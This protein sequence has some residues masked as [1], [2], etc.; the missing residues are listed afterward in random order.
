MG[1]LGFTL[2]VALFCINWA[3][4]VG[5]AGQYGNGFTIIYELI[6]GKA[7]ASG[8]R[9]LLNSVMSF[10]VAAGTIL[11][12]AAA[13]VVGGREYAIPIFIISALAEIFLMP[14]DVLNNVAMPFEIK[15]LLFGL[16][17]IMLISAVVSFVRGE[18]I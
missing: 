7:T 13:I 18:D 14:L 2:L 15:S 12:T 4:Y 3:I 5:S 10:E 8:L 6:S 1:R 17:H 16:F 9:N 11:T